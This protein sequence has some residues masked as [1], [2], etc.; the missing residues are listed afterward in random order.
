M[1]VRIGKSQDFWAGLVFVFC[2]GSAAIIA[3]HYPIGSSSRMGP[4]YLP[5]ILGCMLVFLGVIIVFGSLSRDRKAIQPWKFLP[6]RVVLCSVLAF[7]FLAQSLGLVV[8]I[9]GLTGFSSFGVDGVRP[10]EMLSLYLILTL[11]ALGV[12]AYG[13]GLPFKIWPW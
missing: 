9:L 6:F 10:R 11:M 8:A 4:G 1:K 12:F 5:F 3:R 13:L 2:G 7:A